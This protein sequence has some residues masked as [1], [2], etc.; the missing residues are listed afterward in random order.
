MPNIK[1][2]EKLTPQQQDHVTR[3]IEAHND[4]ELADNFM[5]QKPLRTQYRMEPCWDCRADEYD[6]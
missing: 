6:D 4:Q 5:S 1:G 3:I 2:W